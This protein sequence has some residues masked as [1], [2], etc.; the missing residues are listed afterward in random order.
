VIKQKDE[1]VTG[2][3][4]QCLRTLTP[5]PEVLSSIPMDLFC[6]HL[7][8]LVLQEDST[9]Y[10]FLKTKQKQKHGFQRLNSGQHA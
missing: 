5:L 7:Q 4:A 1:T 3:M 9:N 2:E 6:L 8:D 10:D